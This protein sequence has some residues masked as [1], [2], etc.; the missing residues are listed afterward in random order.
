MHT[1]RKIKIIKKDVVKNRETP[2]V[3][4]ENLNQKAERNLTLTVSDWVS[5]HQ[6]QRRR[7]TKQV[8]LL[9]GK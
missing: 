4:E 9:F 1:E 5:E 7:E 3:T 8:R 2:P 6:Q